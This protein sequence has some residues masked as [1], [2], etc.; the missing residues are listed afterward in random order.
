MG[1]NITG[2]INCNYRIA[3]ALYALEHCFPN[4]FA[5]GPPFGFK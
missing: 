3:A 5:H 2:T 1:D 4:F